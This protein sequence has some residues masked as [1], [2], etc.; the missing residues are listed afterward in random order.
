MQTYHNIVL[1]RYF[2]FGICIIVLA[3][4]GVDTTSYTMTTADEPAATPTVSSVFQWSL[5]TAPTA[6]PRPTRSGTDIFDMT[7]SES[8]TISQ[9]EDRINEITIYDDVLNSN[10]SLHRSTDMAY[11]LEHRQ[12]IKSGLAAIAARPLAESGQLFFAV[13]SDTNITYSRDR[14]QGLS[15]WLNAGSGYIQTSDLAISILGSNV[16]PYW[17]S[18]DASVQVEGILPEGEPLFSE[19]RLY[20]LDINH[21]LPPNTWIEVQVWIDDLIYDPE[22]RYVTGFYIKNDRDFLDNFYIDSISLLV[23][24]PSG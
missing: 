4:C 24:T 1:R 9:Q 20:H 23:E 5:S 19:T 2:W 21:P 3:A 7:L 12:Y 10:W 22:Y 8:L 17:S 15:F 18:D 13:N 6:I 16:Y 11:D 14:V